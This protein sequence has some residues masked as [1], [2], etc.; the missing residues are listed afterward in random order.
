M[1]DFS[2][3][4]PSELGDRQVGLEG[5]HLQG[6]RIALLV[7]GGIAAMKA[8]LIARNLRREGAEVIAFVSKSGLRYVTEETLAWSTNN[9]VITNLTPS[10]EHLSDDNPF[11]L[12]L[13]APATYNTINKFR[14]GIA[15]GIIT[16]TLGS[17]LGRLEGG[18]TKILIVP[19]M[20]GSLHNSILIESL[21]ILHQKG[22]EIMKPRQENGKD[23]IPEERDITVTVCRLLST[24]TLKNKSILV[25]GGPTPVAIDNIRRITNIFTG[26]LGI[27]IADE[28]YLRGANVILI[29]GRSSHKPYPYLP[30]IIINS[31]D[32][33]SRQ[34]LEN[35]A[36]AQVG[37]FTAAVADYQPSEVFN[38]KLPSGITTNNINLLPTAKVI[39]QVKEYFPT[40]YMITFKYQ[41]NIS[42]EQM[43]NIAQERLGKY[44]VVIANRG[45]EKTEEGE[46]IAY[47][48]S[49][50]QPIEK[51]IGKKQI[52][53]GIADYLEKYSQSIFF[54][55]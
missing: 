8:P 3:P 22:V 54:S 6:K 19:T 38:G 52:A 39:E 50:N 25:T 11:H 33:Y 1:W 9:R 12:Y 30:H 47:L 24:S 14:Y 17:A 53:E 23:N 46:Q 48:V 41:E 49:H 44:Q 5:K 31:Y 36:N 2:P 37:I 29:H 45:E 20:H 15:D 16:S 7:T 18:K 13:V 43:I 34:V 32:E 21:Q 27:C 51:M 28:L 4:P 10:A 26:Q 40:L 42:Y 55:Q 35:S